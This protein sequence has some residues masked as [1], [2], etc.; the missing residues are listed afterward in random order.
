MKPVNR[1]L[2]K[3]SQGERK[4]P[5]NCRKSTYITFTFGEK[6]KT[7]MKNTENNQTLEET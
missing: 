4:L 6:K 5:D 2:H 1:T 7:S 3:F